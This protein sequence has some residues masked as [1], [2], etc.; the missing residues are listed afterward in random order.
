MGSNITFQSMV[1]II[2]VLEEFNIRIKVV[3]IY[4]DKLQKNL[5]L[6]KFLFIT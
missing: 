1:K 3:S 6:E 4:H 5:S 2:E